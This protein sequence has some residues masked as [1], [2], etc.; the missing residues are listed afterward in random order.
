MNRRGLGARALNVELQQRLN[1][2][3]E[4][5]VTRF[6]WTYAPGDNVI[7]T[8]NNYD[9][10]LFNGDIGR[11]VGIDEQ[12]GLV[13]ID[14]DARRV[15]H[16]NGGLDEVSLAYAT[17][18]HKS[19]GSR[20]PAVV[21]PIGMPYYMLLERNLLYKAVTRG[22]R[23]VVVIWQTKALAAKRLGPVKRLTNLRYRLR[24]AGQGREDEI[25][26]RADRHRDGQNGRVVGGPSRR[27]AL[28]GTGES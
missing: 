14:Y 7:R 17:T 26:Y 15:E 12:E 23:L 22:K 21:I 28:P 8:V 4:P 13:Y 24:Q 11:V 18:V 1:P 2:N 3:A 16:E 19:Q 10:D 27:A 25:W 5:R 20:Y 6:G 9:K